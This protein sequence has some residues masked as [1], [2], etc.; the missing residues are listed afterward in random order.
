MQGDVSHLP[1]KDGEFDLVTAF[2]TVYFWPGPVQS[3]REVHRVLRGGGRFLIV[4]ESD[5]TNAKDQKWLDMID[6][7]RI[8]TADEMCAM[9]KTAG[10][11]KITV[12]RRKENHWAAFLAEKA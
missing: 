2:E 8:Y 1:L 9:L 11:S 5:G 4:N 7:M 12:F 10:F 3:F 6:G